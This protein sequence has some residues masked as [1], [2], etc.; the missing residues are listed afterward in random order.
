MNRASLLELLKHPQRTTA[1][2]PNGWTEFIATARNA[3]LLGKVAQRLHE[4]GVAVPAAP[5]RHLEGARLLSERQHHSV[6][7]E[8]QCIDATL[9]QTDE[10]VVL[11]KGAA[12][13]LG[14]KAAG[15][16]R[17][18]G[19]VD[20]LVPPGSLGK[21][22]IRLMAGGWTQMKSEEYDQRYY[23]EWMHELP[24]MIHVRRGTVIDVHHTILPLTARSHPDADAIIAHSIL[25]PGY[26]SLR[27]PCD[28]DLIIHSM[29]HLAHEGELH[30]ALR[31]LDDINS[32][33]SE[34][35]DS[36][37]FWGQLG[38]RAEHHDLAA[39]VALCL[40][41]V[42]RFFDTPV[43]ESLVLR[44]AGADATAIRRLTR[45]Y[46]V[47][48][49][50]DPE[51]RPPLRSLAAQ[52]LIY[53]RSHWLRMP[54]RLLVQHLSRKAWQRLTLASGTSPKNKQGA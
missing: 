4:A 5:L 29:C 6:A 47:A 15:V 45:L 52:L 26:R 16:G 34:H 11:L 33:L 21:I 14:R 49:V 42:R 31:D 41:L 30:N 39:S 32:L 24:P 40:M 18:F 8:A 22:E 38:D 35:A 44:L 36:P 27:I 9:A 13:V 17:L 7:W 12:Y 48:I 10:P 51:G 19:D 20:V 43:P 54:P 46:D 28:E 3:N 50:P 23:R 25:L 1:L 2:S 37:D 53:I